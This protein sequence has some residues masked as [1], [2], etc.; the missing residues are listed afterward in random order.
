M[1]KKNTDQSKDFFKSMS[2]ME[3]KYFDSLKEIEKDFYLQSKLL[4]QDHNLS[5]LKQKKADLKDKIL[6]YGN[7]IP[8]I[9]PLDSD[10]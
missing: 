9:V 6:E 1:A 10:S 5:T 2:E 3:R 8:S 4:Y 7:N